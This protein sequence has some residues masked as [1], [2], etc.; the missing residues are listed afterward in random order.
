MRAACLCHMTSLLIYLWELPT[1]L[2]DLTYHLFVRA[3]YL[4]CF[5]TLLIY[6]WA[7]PICVTWSNVFISERCLP[8]L[9]DLTYLFVR[10]I[11][12]WVVTWPNLTFRCEKLARF[13]C[14]QYLKIFCNFRLQHSPPLLSL[15]YRAENE[16]LIIKKEWIVREVWST[17]TRDQRQ[18][19][20]DRE[21]TESQKSERHREWKIGKETESQR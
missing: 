6:L 4:C 14:W 21:R 11:S 9:H 18:R 7:L 10:A 8:V 17:S 5:M 2:H 19:V 16:M 13:L 15:L 3:A 12:T 1:M 20:K